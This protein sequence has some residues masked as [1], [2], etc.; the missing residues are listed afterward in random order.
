[1]ISTE[2]ITL[3]VDIIKFSTAI[4]ELKM[5]SC[6]ITDFYWVLTLLSLKNLKYL[7]LSHNPIILT[8]SCEIE[9][10]SKSLEN[11]SL[12]YLSLFN[13]GLS[14]QC[15]HKVI[16]QLNS[17]SSLQYLNLNSNTIDVCPV[18]VNDIATLVSNN[19]QMSDFSLPSC[20]L[21][22]DMMRC[23]FD[24]IKCVKSLRHIDFST[25]Q[26]NDSLADDLAALKASSD[27]LVELRFSEMVLTHGGFTQL[28][29]SILIVRGLNNISITG[30]HL[31]DTNTCNLITVITNNKQLQVLDISDCVIPELKKHTVFIAMI[32]VTSLKSLKLNNIVI[33]DTIE[34]TVLAVLANNANLNYLEIIGC[35]MNTARL[36][37]VSN[38]DKLKV[39]L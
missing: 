34:D 27:D 10:K 37:A 14:A 3:L 23:I 26:V 20:S 35:K 28:G 24:G 22:N 32:D 11:D 15:T 33:S 13:C 12:Q 38:F 19:P 30:V 36:N 39:V 31:T 25:N 8:K 7:D 17:F 18:V 29:N 2:N 1:M 5:S 4:D 6:N 9:Q 16:K 21:S